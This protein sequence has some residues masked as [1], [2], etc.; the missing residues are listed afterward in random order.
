MDYDPR[1]DDGDVR[2]IPMLEI[3]FGADNVPLPLTRPAIEVM[4]NRA[5]TATMQLSQ[6]AGDAT[7]T[8]ISFDFETAGSYS[9]NFYEGACPPAGDPLLESD[10]TVTDGM[11]VTLAATAGRATELADGDHVIAIEGG[12]E[13]ACEP[14]GNITNGTYADKMIDPEPLDP[15]GVSVRE[16]DANGTLLAYAPLNVVTDPVGGANVAFAARMLYWR[17]SDRG[18]EWAQAQQ[19]RV[20][21]LVQMLTDEC[22]TTGFAPSAAAQEPAEGF[23]AQYASEREAWCSEPGHRTADAPRIVQT[24]DE[25][26]Y[27]TGLMVREDLGMDVAIVWEDPA[28]DNDR[29]AD[30]RLWQAARGLLTSFVSGRDED[31]NGQLDLGINERNGADGTIEERLDADGSVPEGDDKRWGIPKNALRVQSYEFPHEDYVGQIATQDARAILEAEFSPVVQAGGEITPTLLFAREET[32]IGLDLTDGSMVNGSVTLDFDGHTSITLAQLSWAP[33]RYNE[34]LGPDRQPIGWERHPTRLYWDK[35]EAQFTAAFR[36]LPEEVNEFR[37]DEY[38]VIG[39]MLAARSLYF[40]IQAGVTSFVQMGSENE[41]PQPDVVLPY[42]NEGNLDSDAGIATGALGLFSSSYDIIMTFMEDMIGEGAENAGKSA[43]LRAA[44]TG[45][46]RSWAAATLVTP[47]GAPAGGAAGSR[48]AA[49]KKWFF[50]TEGKGF[51]GI[52]SSGKDSCINLVNLHVDTAQRGGRATS[53]GT[54]LVALA[55]LAGMIAAVA[56]VATSENALEGASWALAAIGMVIEVKGVI[57]GIR[58]WSTATA[59]TAGV[60]IGATRPVSKITKLGNFLGK[61]FKS[62]SG[63]L[64]AAGAIVSGVIT[65]AVFA[66]QAA[67][68]D[69]TYRQM[70]NLVAQT[71]GQTIVLVI[72]FIIDLIPIVGG[73]ITGIISIIDGLVAAICSVFGWDQEK[74]GQNDPYDDPGDWL[75]GGIEGLVS[76]FLAWFIYAGNSMV[77]ME[78]EGRLQFD[79][80]Q[81]NTLHDPEMGLVTGNILDVGV[82]VTTTL[83][84]MGRPSNVGGGYYWQFRDNFRKSTFEYKVQVEETDSEGLNLGDQ[85]DEW[86]DVPYEEG[87]EHD[88]G[89][90]TMHTEAAAYGVTLPAAGINRE[91]AVYVSEGYIVPVQNCY[92]GVC[93]VDDER[94]TIHYPLT[95]TLVFDVLPATLDEFYSRSWGQ[96]YSIGLVTMPDKDGDGLTGGDPND[97]SQDTDGDGLIDPRELQF[98]ASPTMVDTDGDSISDYDETQIGTDPQR[99]DTDGDGLWD[100]QEVYHQDKGDADNDDDRL[101]WL[102]GWRYVYRINADNEQESAWVTSNPEK[103]DTDDDGLIDRD[104]LLYGF[105]PTVW[106]NAKVLSLDTQLQEVAEVARSETGHSKREETGPASGRRPATA[107]GKAGATLRQTAWFSPVQPSTT[108]RPSPTSC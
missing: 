33:Y 25:A 70:G 56:A 75:C 79:D 28:A 82:V 48:A 6:N 83:T 101:E 52:G 23:A 92:L 63:K 98:G 14:L 85:E 71:I 1:L 29:N 22:D 18:M 30:D 36:N 64:A 34:A 72:M 47:A 26:W 8:D 94:D 97:M 77:D 87:E 100:G 15:Y 73:I 95:D 12:G 3:T 16:K 84:M 102:G 108:R 78:A 60:V 31:G 106:S 69:L 46:P 65:W 74:A 39:Q 21:W 32:S 90:I 53:V 58:E 68:M 38:A 17:D 61:T 62:T 104:E 9:V 40:T 66:V 91:L 19:V 7:R 24:Y 67:L 93:V 51:R 76:T 41:G 35:L 54:A 96:D 10:L 43:V 5:I 13:T 4:A 55:G 49:A 99:K 88:R 103:V 45:Q 59:K 42:T 80:L 11:T 105:N 44:A 57:D 50:Q 37:D 20:V 107:S 27:L 89:D 81:A 86:I 2:L